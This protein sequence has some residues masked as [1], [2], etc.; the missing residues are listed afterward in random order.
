MVSCT[1]IEPG[2][3]KMPRF[4]VFDEY[5]LILVE[6]DNSR[7]GWGIVRLVIPIQQVLVYF[8]NY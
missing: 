5:R 3:F 6:P 1:L 8:I 2:G 4:L 7:L